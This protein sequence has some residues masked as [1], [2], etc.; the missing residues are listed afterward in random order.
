MSPTAPHQLQPLKLMQI[1]SSSLENEG[2]DSPSARAEI[3]LGI[4]SMH[5][6]CLALR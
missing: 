4:A 6:F 5:A 3:V 2:E 1:A